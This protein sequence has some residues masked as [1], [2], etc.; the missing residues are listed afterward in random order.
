MSG[1]SFAQEVAR[2]LPTAVVLASQDVTLAQ[3]LAREL[4]GPRLRIYSSDDLVGIEV[5][6]AAKNVIAIAAGICDGLGLGLTA[7]AALISRGLAEISRLGLRLGGHVATFMGLAG[8]GDLVLTCTGELSRNRTVGL[9]LALIELVLKR[10]ATERRADLARGTHDTVG[11]LDGVAL[12]AT[13]ER[14]GGDHSGALEAVEH[15]PFSIGSVG[16]R[17]ADVTMP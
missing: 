14:Q 13:T 9:R 2:G 11:A 17:P 16:P 12:D 8:A 6:G 5:A 4:H 1:P 7:R 10:A 15:D 3:R